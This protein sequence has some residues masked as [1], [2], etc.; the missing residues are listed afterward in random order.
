MKRFLL[1]F[2]GIF[3]YTVNYSQYHNI[4]DWCL[5]IPQS[6][7]NAIYSVGVSDPRSNEN[8]E[9]AKEI[10]LRRAI[11]CA[12]LMQNAKIDYVADYFK[13]KTEEHRWFI[14]QETIEELSKISASAYID[15]N[16]YSVID[17]FVNTN[18]EY[19]VLIRYFPVTN[20]NHNFKVYAEYFRKEFE[21]SNTRA[22][23]SIQSLS[24]ESNWKKNDN[25][26]A[27]NNKYILTNIN[28]NLNI[29][30]LYEKQE[31]KSPGYF[32][33]YKNICKDTFRIND[34]G[35]SSNMQKGFWVS[36]IASFF[37]TGNQIAINKN[38]KMANISDASNET[39]NDNLIKNEQKALTRQISSNNISYY[40]K[41][42]CINDNE[43]YPLFMYLG[44]TKI[45][46]YEDENIKLDDI[47]NKSPN[48]IWYKRL[49]KFKRKQ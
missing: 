11:E 48:I 19:F 46:L 22:M 31:I 28:N 6:Y 23:E 43:L 17:S 5:N 35:L 47:N 15:D 39:T 37:R 7:K 4:A 30:S 1:I 20:K 13:L 45:D 34:F 12:I 32:Y 36:Y 16:S 3:I 44:N 26:S 2:F 29:K 49:F 18:G 40:L 25:D 8:K 10:A 21:V 27:S 24:I 14:M 33:R 41:Y 38:S 42:I 9:I